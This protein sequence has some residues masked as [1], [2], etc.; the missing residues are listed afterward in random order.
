MSGSWNGAVNSVFSWAAGFSLFFVFKSLSP[1]LSPPKQFE[2]LLNEF[3]IHLRSTSLNRC[4]LWNG[5]LLLHRYRL[6]GKH[7]DKWPRTGS[8]S[9]YFTD[10][11]GQLWLLGDFGTRTAA[12]L[13]QQH[14]TRSGQRCKHPAVLIKNGFYVMLNKKCTKLVTQL[15]HTHKHC[16]WSGRRQAKLQQ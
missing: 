2:S 6:G 7:A 11:T 10:T 16:H 9:N 4:S 15:L 8:R 3:P 1:V 14:R 12:A 13:S 5:F